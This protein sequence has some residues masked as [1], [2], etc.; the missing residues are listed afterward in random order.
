MT[1][2]VIMIMTTISLFPRL[3]EAF[4]IRAVAL[5]MTSCPADPRCGTFSV[6]RRAF[7]VPNQKQVRVQIKCACVRVCV[8]LFLQSDERNN[9]HKVECVPASTVRCTAL[10]CITDGFISSKSFVYADKKTILSVNFRAVFSSCVLC[11]LTDA[12]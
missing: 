4:L 8:R 10:A 2:I 5:K 9:D 12:L 1:M 11:S 3:V 7:F 6:A